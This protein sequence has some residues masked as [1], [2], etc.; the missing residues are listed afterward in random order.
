M[1][2]MIQGTSSGAGKTML[3]TALCRIFTQEGYRVAPFKAQ[4]MS[5]FVYDAGSFEISQAQAVQAIAA[6]CEISP[7][8]NP[9]LLKPEGSDTSMI[10]IHGRPL[11]K[12]RPRDYYDS[13]AKTRG[14]KTAS[15]ALDRLRKEY[16]LVI[17]EGAGSPA[18]INLISSD[19]ANM[20]MAQRAHA[21]VL[22]V[23]DIERGGAFAS[24]TG[25]L[26]LLTSRDQRLVRGFI[27]NKFRGDPSILKPG[28]TKLYKMTR[29]PVLGTIPVIS[30]DLPE[31]DSLGTAPAQSAWRQKDIR[32]MDKQ[33]DMLAKLVKSSINMDRIRSMLS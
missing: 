29:R 32:H 10:Y 8:L 31:E 24:L 22:L 5:R 11:R 28:Y 13:F 6:R 2:L 4:N 15:A 16:D 14:L 33:I 19:I 23:T 3:V 25:T 20:K 12:M 9:V 27:I 17:L 26:N 1:S 18:E 7:D 30:F 21:P